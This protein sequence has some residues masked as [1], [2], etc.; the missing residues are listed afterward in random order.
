VCAVC[1]WEIKLSISILFLF[2][3]HTCLRLKMGKLKSDICGSITRRSMGNVSMFQEIFYSPRCLAF[4]RPFFV[5]S[6]GEKMAGL[7]VY[8]TLLLN[9]ARKRKLNRHRCCQCDVHCLISY[10]CMYQPCNTEI[11]PHLCRLLTTRTTTCPMRL[12]GV[13]TQVHGLQYT[14]Y[15]I[16]GYCNGGCRKLYLITTR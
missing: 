8:I 2:C 4:N 13:G 11:Y 12:G 16:P 14:E 5:I 3:I 9:F 1:C 7:C 10:I 15:R 6:D